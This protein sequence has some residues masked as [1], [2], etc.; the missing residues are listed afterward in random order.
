MNPDI[1]AGAI[2]LTAAILGFSYWITEQTK[3]RARY[4]F[5]ARKS[6]EYQQV[7]K[8]ADE[9]RQAYEEEKAKTD[10]LN[11]LLRV[12]RIVMEK[13]KIKDLKDET[14]GRRD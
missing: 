6:K 12:Q 7:R 13:T 10:D 1:I 2:I 8:E 11:A 14:D 9:W 5:E 4:S 3:I